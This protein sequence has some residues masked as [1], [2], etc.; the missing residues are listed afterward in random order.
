M[1]INR[2]TPLL[3]AL[4]ISIF[5]LILNAPLFS[6]FLLEED[7]TEYRFY[8][9]VSCGYANNTLY[10]SNPQQE[11]PGRKWKSGGGVA[12]SV[13][14]RYR[15]LNSVAI[16]LEPTYI[17]KN[18]SWNEARSGLPETHEDTRNDFINFPVMLNLS[19][20]FGSGIRIFVNGGGYYGYWLAGHEKGITLTIDEEPYDYNE[21]YK[22]DD[23]RD[24]RYEYGLSYGGGIQ[25]DLKFMSVYIELRGSHGLSDL[26]KNYYTNYFTEK[27]NDTWTL[28]FA[29][30]FN[31]ALI[32]FIKGEAL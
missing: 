7:S 19:I 13:P 17:Q 14:L 10:L 26:Q 2:K 18:Y 27:K 29:A 9:G 31:T 32:S 4:F 5:S 28:Q 20:Y 12:V 24:N 6:Q 15:L 16:Q 8:M 11:S 3:F 30:I 1:R 22:F 21:D 25:Y 23:I